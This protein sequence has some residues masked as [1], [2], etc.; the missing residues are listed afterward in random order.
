MALK[1]KYPS[2]RFEWYITT[3]EQ[4]R[5]EIDTEA[6]IDKYHLILCMDV[7]YYLN[8]LSDTLRHLYRLLK[9][10]AV[11]GITTICTKSV[12]GNFYLNYYKDKDYP[13]CLNSDE[14]IMKVVT[15]SGW[16]TELKYTPVC[17]DMTSVIHNP[18]SEEANMLLD[19]I[20]HVIDYR[21]SAPKSLVGDTLAYLTKNAEYQ[22]DGK[23]T[24]TNSK[25][26]IIITKA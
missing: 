11:L 9:P 5:R 6:E 14:D 18:M 17:V 4:Y 15:T 3:F 26:E 19:F 25:V 12:L 16:L 8:D 20:T 2:I 13:V 23:E 1:K 10:K 24:V 7:L 22:S 21:N